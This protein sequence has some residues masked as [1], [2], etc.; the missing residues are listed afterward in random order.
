MVTRKPRITSIPEGTRD[1]ATHRHQQGTI[2]GERVLIDDLA[3]FEGISVIGVN[4][5]C[6][7]N[8]SSWTSRLP[9]IVSHHST[10]P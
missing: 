6:M 10:G 5:Y 4:E 9:D 3:Q 7:K 2:Q 8:T 1:R